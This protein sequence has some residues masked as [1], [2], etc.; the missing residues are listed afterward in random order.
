PEEYLDR[1]PHELSGGQQQRIGVLRALAANPP[2]ILMDEPF[3]ALDPITRDSLQ[4]EFKKLQKE[5]DKT[6]VFVTHDMDEAINL[7]G[8]IVQADTREEI[9]SNPANE[10]V[11]EFLGKDLLIQGR[12]DVATVGQVMEKHPIVVETGT[13]LKSAV[14]IMREKRVDSLLIVNGNNELQG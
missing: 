10:F 8:E 1:Y 12:P 6:I 5:L 14:S 13:T 4:D 11:E 2:L 9:I 3:G 7:A